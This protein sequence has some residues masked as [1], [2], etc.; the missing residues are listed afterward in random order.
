MAAEFRFG[1]VVRGQAEP[2]EDIAQRFD[3]TVGFVR[4]AHR[5]GYDSITKTAHYSASPFQMLQHLKWRRAVMRGLCDRVVA[6]PMRQAHK[7][8]RFI[9]ALGDILARLGLAANDKSKA[10][11]RSHRWSVSL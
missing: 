6:E 11:F 7:A 8:D 1:L 4:L 10:K 9:E 5:L 3:E 2:G